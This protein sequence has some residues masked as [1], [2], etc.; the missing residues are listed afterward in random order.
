MPQLRL[1]RLMKPGGEGGRRER[2]RSGTGALGGPDCMIA[3]MDVDDNV[4]Q[5]GPA[6]IQPFLRILFFIPGWTWR[7]APWPSLQ[8]TPCSWLG[9]DSRHTSSLSLSLSPSFSPVFPD[10]QVQVGCARSTWR[11][12]ACTTTVAPAFS[13]GSH[14]LGR[15][16]ASSSNFC[17]SLPRGEDYGNETH[18]K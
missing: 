10:L 12:W 17:T 4:T 1:L 15:G 3:A 11:T 7:T 2:L 18:S 13:G 8:I 6:T 5:H 14:A 16:P 9:S